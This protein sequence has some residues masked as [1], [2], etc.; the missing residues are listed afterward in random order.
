MGTNAA[1]K[2]FEY[3]EGSEIVGFDISMAQNV[4]KDMG[5]KLQVEDMAF[6]SLLSALDTGTIDFVA[7]GMTA[8]ESAARAS[9][10]PSPTTPPSRS[11]SSANKQ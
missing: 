8:T 6:D 4:A 5:R 3:A 9:T 2:P 10:S 11:S 1:F 7:A